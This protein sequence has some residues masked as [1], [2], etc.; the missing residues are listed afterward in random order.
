MPC[1][2]RVTEDKTSQR[3]GDGKHNFYLEYR[4]NMPCMTGKDICEKCVI[5]Y[6]K[7]KIQSSRKFNHGKV[8][9]P[10]TEYSH[11][12][13]GKWYKEKVAVWG[14]PPPDVIKFALEYQKEARGDYI[15][16]DEE[17]DKISV[18]K[19]GQQTI[20]QGT[21][22]MPRGKK[23]QVPTDTNEND[24]K[25]TDDTVTKVVKQKRTRKPKIVVG[26]NVEV[27]G[28]N[29]GYN[30][31]VTEV[32]TAP[33]TKK[34]TPPGPRSRATTKSVK[35]T[36]VVNISP[37]SKKAQLVNTLLNNT[38]DVQNDACIPL[39]IERSIDTFNIDDCEIEY[40]TLSIFQHNG[41]EYYRDSNKNKLYK[42]L[43]DRQ[44]GP[45]IGRYY[46]PSDE[47]DTDIPDSDE[48]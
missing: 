23:K 15:I 45:Y 2:S 12:F 21:I 36:N 13:G 16:V 5:K 33:T 9:E 17:N 34:R 37:R 35:T 48:E 11:I 39:Y 3:F 10:I 42:K 25:V 40:V 44:I 32:E 46:A 18:H 30:T 22:I 1:M 47:I 29:E 38:S 6:D 19:E 28:K 24:S 4:C 20:I 8:N 14:E 41:T 43:K 31:G 27:D 26:D 7:H